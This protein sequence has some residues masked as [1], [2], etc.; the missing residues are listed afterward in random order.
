MRDKIKKNI[1]WVFHKL[2]ALCHFDKTQ[3]HRIKTNNF[4]RFQNKSV[5]SSKRVLSC[6][7]SNG[8]TEVEKVAKVNFFNQS[9]CLIPILWLCSR[10][11]FFIVVR[12]SMFFL[13]RSACKSYQ[14][15]FPLFNFSSHYK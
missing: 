11:F 3:T 5:L 6:Q 9:L 1:L 15:F 13:S 8:N 14:D 7:L 12:F 4:E 2:S 10:T